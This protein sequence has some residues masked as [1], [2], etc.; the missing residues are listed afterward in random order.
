[1]SDLI[2]KRELYKKLGDVYNRVLKD[3]KEGE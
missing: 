2:N 3:E 1:M